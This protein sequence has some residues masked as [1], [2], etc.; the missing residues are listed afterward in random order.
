MSSLPFAVTALEDLL[1]AQT[2]HLKAD[3]IFGR[4]LRNGDK[5]TNYV[6]DLLYDALV[7]GQISETEM[8]QVLATDLLW[9]GEERKT[10]QPLILVIEAR[11]LAKTTDVERVATRAAILRRIGLNALA[12]VGGQEWTE[13]ARQ[14]A[15]NA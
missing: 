5:A 10:K 6:A 15:R 13:A 8:T 1:E 12:V 2:Y 9:A 4:Y 11:W 7:D 14:Q 3:M